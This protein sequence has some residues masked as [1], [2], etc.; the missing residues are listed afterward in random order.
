MSFRPWKSEWNYKYFCFISLGLKSNSYQKHW[1]KVI[2]R[3]TLSLSLSFSLFWEPKRELGI[4]MKWFWTGVAVVSHYSSHTWYCVS[5][6]RS[7]QTVMKTCSVRL[8]RPSWC[9]HVWIKCGSDVG[10]EP[11]LKMWYFMSNHTSS[12]D[13]F[14]KS[15]YL[16]ILCVCYPIWWDSF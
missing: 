2:W 16:F 4:I 11:K 10:E 7:S 3:E 1:Y 14:K 9:C 12:F 8:H 5:R 6:H 13:I 15:Y